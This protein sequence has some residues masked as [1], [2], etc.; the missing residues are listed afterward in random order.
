MGAVAAGRWCRAPEKQAQDAP[1]EWDVGRCVR[2]GKIA[3][4]HG[5]RGE[6]K[7]YPY[8]RDP[9]ALAAYGVVYLGP[10]VDDDALALDEVPS[11]FQRFEV[12]R[13]R[14]QGKFAIV[15]LA[16]MDNRNEAEACAGLELWVDEALLPPA[17]EDE[18]YWHEVVGMRAVT[19][20]G[21]DLG[22]VRRLFETGAHDVL[23]IGDERREYLVPARQE[24]IERIDL[25]EKVLVVRPLPGLL[26]ANE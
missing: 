18:F 26:E 16:G 4:A 3:K 24:F 20:E 12:V 14:T 5:I 11:S 2:V 6:V 25:H 17:G 15:A 1:Q 7:V 23:V 22:L 13:C 21:R 10:V 9:E 8:S 19:G